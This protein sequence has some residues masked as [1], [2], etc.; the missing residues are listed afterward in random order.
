MKKNESFSKIDGIFFSVCCGFGD[1][2]EV[3]CLGT[4]GKT[5]Y[6]ACIIAIHSEE[7]TELAQS[8]V[9]IKSNVSS[10]ITQNETNELEIRC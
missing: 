2:R 8:S 7:E 3:I 1:R 9:S 5:R 10:K 6:N 4:S